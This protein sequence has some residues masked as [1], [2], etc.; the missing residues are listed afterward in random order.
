MSS[1]P[2]VRTVDTLLSGACIATCAGEGD[3]LA[4][5]DLHEGWSVGLV[6]D[7][8]A[9]LGPSSSEPAAKERFDL[10]GCSILP[11]L[12]DP[13][14]HLPFA[15]TR[16]HELARKLAGEDYRVIAAEGGGIASTV[17]ATREASEERL[18]VLAKARALQMRAHGVTAIE[19]KSGYGLSVEHELRL[20]RVLRRLDD[21]GLMRVT[22]SF[23]GAHAL[24]PERKG[25]RER[26]LDEVVQEQLPRVVDEG[27]ADAIDVYCDDGAFTLAEA[28]RVLE[29]GRDL[30]LAVRAHAGQF[31]DLGAAEL[32]AELGGLSADHL[33]A[34]SDEGLAAMAAAGVVGVFLPGA[35][36]TLRQTAPDGARFRAAGVSVAV[37]TDLN[38]GTSPTADLPLAAALAMRDGG[39]TSEEALLGITRHAARAAGFGELGSLR[40]GGLADL[41]VFDTPT[42]RTLPYVL[43]DVRAREV[44]VGGRCVHRSPASLPW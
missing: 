38:P 14:T 43:G 31:A 36:R 12:V 33:E 9:Y 24:P 8:V 7:R 17:R 41:A 4:Q 10:E 44:W 22:T 11:G 21:E 27:L 3:A 2:V 39:L 29:A 20:L 25:E 1:A 32:V 15:G 16:V 19:A 23:L 26:Y 6:A 42:P 35:W 30:G 40:V 37:G 5:L 34:V 13:H 28:R 18:Y